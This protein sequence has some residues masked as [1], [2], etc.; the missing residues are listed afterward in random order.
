MT[1][2]RVAHG[3]V[4]CIVWL[5]VPV[6]GCGGS[7]A[8]PTPSSLGSLSWV[9]DW[10]E[11]SREIPAPTSALSVQVA[12][13]T[14]DG[15]SQLA[16]VPANRPAGP[17]RSSAPMS[18]RSLPYGRHRVTVTFYSKPDQQ[19]SEVASALVEATVDEEEVSLGTVTPVGVVKRVVVTPALVTVGNSVQLTSTAYT[20]AGAV[21]ALTEG[22]ARWSLASGANFAT[23]TPAGE[24]HGIAAGTAGARAIVDGVTSD[25]APIQVVEPTANPK[26]NTL[27]GVLTYDSANHDRKPDTHEFCVEPWLTTLKRFGAAGIRQVRTTISYDPGTTGAFQ[28]ETDQYAYLDAL[29][30]NVLGRR[31]PALRTSGFRPIVLT[32]Q[33]YRDGANPWPRS[34]EERRRFV[35]WVSGILS[36]V[37]ALGLYPLGDLLVQ[38]GNEPSQATIGNRKV[39]LS[40][41]EDYAMTLRDVLDEVDR[42]GPSVR[43]VSGAYNNTDFPGSVPTFTLD[44]WLNLLHGRGILAR[45]YGVALHAYRGRYSD[46]QSAYVPEASHADIVRIRERLGPGQEA[47]ITEAGSHHTIRGG[48]AGFAYQERTAIRYLLLAL[49]NDVKH[50]ILYE[51]KDRKGSCTGV[52]A[53]AA[54]SESSIVSELNFGMMDQAHNLHPSGRSVISI[55]QTYGGFWREGEQENVTPYRHRLIITDG[56]ARVRVQWASR[57]SDATAEFPLMP[58]FTPNVPAPGRPANR[59]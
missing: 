14:K 31:L 17:G 53:G 40:E 23:L 54:C 33:T 38:I 55:M 9:I 10:P 12:V 7:G 52:V 2:R 58:T 8:H 6:S 15:T 35:R 11:R 51:A 21:V 59:H 50:L 20:S 25:V 48:D 18:A 46:D 30:D 28:T 57:E 16:V 3:I 39:T 44:E 37:Q 42:A 36:R 43:V 32:F 45:L 29:I 49:A 19:G 27:V 13:T 47:I 4:L 24:A 5:A 1:Y 34:V 22:S 26:W 56:V 41:V